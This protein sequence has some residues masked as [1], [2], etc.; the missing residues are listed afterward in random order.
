M[1]YYTIYVITNKINGKK[2]IGKHETTNLEDKYLGSGLRLINAIN[3]YGKENFEK[4]I[5]FI[6][7]NEEEMNNKEKELITEDIVMSNM[8]YNISYGGYG[9]ITVL[10]SDH[11]LYDQTRNKIKQT[12]KNKSEFLSLTAKENHKLKKIGMY[13]KTQSDKQKK[14]VSDSAKTRIRSE[15]ERNKIRESYF[16]TISQPG[17]IHP[18]KG[19]PR[20]EEVKQA[21]REK[22]KNEPKKQCIYCGIITN[23][24]NIARHHNERCK[25]KNV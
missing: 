13:G 14:A 24:G 8:Y 18:H 1:K 11:P 3:K 10:K 23:P 2:Y 12:Q 4:Q 16:N 21:I 17:Y 15:E 6:F 25:N 20:S 22:K 7:D 5:L 9:G 19:K